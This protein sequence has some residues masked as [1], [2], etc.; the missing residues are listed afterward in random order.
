MQAQHSCRQGARSREQATLGSNQ[1][2]K[3]T[4][5]ASACDDELATGPRT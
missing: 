4:S 3:L 5:H 1:C 2:C